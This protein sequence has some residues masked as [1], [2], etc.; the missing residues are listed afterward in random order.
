MARNPLTQPR[1]WCG[2]NGRS[3]LAEVG[4]VST[5]YDVE[6][7]PFKKRHRALHC[8]LADVHS[9]RN[10]A[11]EHSAC[12]G[13]L[14]FSEDA[15][16]GGD[17]ADATEQPPALRRDQAIDP[18]ERL[19]APL[20]QSSLAF[21]FS[22][23]VRVHRLGVGR[24]VRDRIERRPLLRRH[25]SYELSA[26]SR[27][28]FVC[29][30]CISHLAYDAFSDAAYVGLVLHSTVFWWFVDAESRSG[31]TLRLFRAVVKSLR[32]TTVDTAFP[33]QRQRLVVLPAIERRCRQRYIEPGRP[34]RTAVGAAQRV[35]VDG[36]D[37]T[38]PV[39]QKAPL[40]PVIVL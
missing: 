17:N 2:D 31:H 36:L 1:A 3:A 37:P 18:V 27:V 19:D 11:L 26:G 6:P 34:D 16:R 32:V 35:P 39:A 5:W 33:L 23:P 15:V 22:L 20:A 12:P 4:I 14:D 28:D 25:A 40:R 9:A 10:R 13:L 21:P 38:G 24:C 30:V 29:R 7:C 8:F